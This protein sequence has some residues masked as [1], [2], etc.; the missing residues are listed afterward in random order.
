VKTC[1]T[2]LCPVFLSSVNQRAGLPAGPPGARP[3]PAARPG[4]RRAGRQRLEFPAQRGVLH[5]SEVEARVQHRRESLSQQSVEFP[6]RLGAPVRDARVLIEY[7]CGHR[8]SP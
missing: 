3:P 6:L 8:R 4:W 1:E 5:R 7:A 2:L